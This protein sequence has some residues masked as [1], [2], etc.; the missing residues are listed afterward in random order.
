M[1]ESV[2]SVVLL[3]VSAALLLPAA[4]A[5]EHTRY[6]S[7]TGRALVTVVPDEISFSA[8]IEAEG[9]E[10]EKVRAEAERVLSGMLRFLKD[11]GV[12]EKDVLSLDLELNRRSTGA[13]S[14]V[15]TERGRQRVTQ[16]R[17]RYTYTFK[18]RVNVILRK[19]EGA[20]AIVTGLVAQG[21]NSIGDFR[22]MLSG[23]KQRLAEVEELAAKD[24]IRQADILCAQ[25]GA[26][27]GKVTSL[28][29]AAPDSADEGGRVIVTGSY[30]PPKGAFSA[31][32]MKL[33]AAVAATFELE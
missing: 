12:P 15:I 9:E 22:F 7:V 32:E 14:E 28:S 25:F 23:E 2:K 31:G 16:T 27:R 18:R 21:A 10:L 20:E 24:A 26:K 3:A 19:V 5:A 33:A 4:S 30:L 13:D 6:V 1:R 11:N 17:V 8:G 29:R